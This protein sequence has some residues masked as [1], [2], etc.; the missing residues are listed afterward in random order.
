MSPNFGPHASQRPHSPFLNSLS[1]SP[2][3]CINIKKKHYFFEA[4]VLQL[5]FEIR[6]DSFTE[7]ALY[8]SEHI[9]LLKTN[10]GSPRSISSKIGYFSDLDHL[11]G[12]PLRTIS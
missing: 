6:L 5:V 2:A 9:L 8:F 10:H 3:C 11:D 12:E 1:G 7:D 4:D